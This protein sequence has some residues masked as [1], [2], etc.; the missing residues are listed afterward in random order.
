MLQTSINYLDN[1]HIFIN[2]LKEKTKYNILNNS[3]IIKIMNFKE[4]SIDILFETEE[5]IIC[6]YVNYSNSKSNVSELNKFINSVKEINKISINN[7]INKKYYAI[8]LSKLE[9]TPSC[10]NILNKE[11]INFEKTSNIK[12]FTIYNNCKEV[13]LTNYSLDLNIL[14]RLQSKLHSLGI[15]YYDKDDTIIMA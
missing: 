5:S 12:F 13:L 7:N 2:E 4:S 14:K 6:I 15:Y 9:P 3:E 11:N 1:K 10:K 8:Y